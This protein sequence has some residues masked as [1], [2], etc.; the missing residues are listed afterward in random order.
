MADVE[1]RM[2]DNTSI[3]F[4]KM[5]DILG[6]PY[7]RLYFSGCGFYCSELQYNIEAFVRLY[8]NQIFFGLFDDD[9]RRIAMTIDTALVININTGEEGDISILASYNQPDANVFNDTIERNEFNRSGLIQLIR[10]IVPKKFIS[11]ICTS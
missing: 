7:Q 1:I 2:S 8:Y 6:L 11:R 4:E 5:T 9:G 10:N 3:E